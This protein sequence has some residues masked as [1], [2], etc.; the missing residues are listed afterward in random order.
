MQELLLTVSVIRSARTVGGGAGVPAIV[1]QRGLEH[2]NPL[3]TA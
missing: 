3:R 2:R 1:G